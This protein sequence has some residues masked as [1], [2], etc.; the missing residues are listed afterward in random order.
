M[1]RRHIA[2]AYQS[3][4][5]YSPIVVTEGGRTIWLAG[6]IAPEDEQGRSLAQDFDGQ[7]RCIFR[8]MSGMLA[9]VAVLTQH[10]RRVPVENRQARNGS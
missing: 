9:D 3:S 8:K 1:K 7:V 10:I 5:S 4:R 2:S 6:I